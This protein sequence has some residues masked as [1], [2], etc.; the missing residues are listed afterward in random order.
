VQKVN[1]DIRQNISFKIDNLDNRKNTGMN[2]VL[3]LDYAT[4]DWIDDTDLILPRLTQEF[5][6]LSESYN[7]R[8]TANA[9]WGDR[10]LP[11]F[12]EPFLDENLLKLSDAKA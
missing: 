8:S 5:P 1:D 10:R 4:R 11:V 6:R 12:T 7:K 9:P 2:D 3:S